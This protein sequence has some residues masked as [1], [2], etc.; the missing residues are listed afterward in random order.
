MNATATEKPKPTKAHVWVRC[1][2]IHDARESIRW[3]L[4]CELGTYPRFFEW[5]Y[6]PPMQ[7]WYVDKNGKGTYSKTPMVKITGYA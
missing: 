4:N 5:D 1:D 2:A 7:M 3:T 6:L